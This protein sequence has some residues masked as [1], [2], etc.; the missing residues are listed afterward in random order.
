LAWRET[1]GHQRVERVE[2]DIKQREIGGFVHA[3]DS[4]GTPRRLATWLI[5]SHVAIKP[6][7]VDTNPHDSS[8]DANALYDAVYGKRGEAENRTKDAQ[9][10]LL[11]T[12]ASCHRS[13]ANECQLLLSSLARTPMRAL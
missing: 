2:R 6:R 12:R 4:W 10:G 9:F 8:Y 3:A 7:F 13:L 1:R 5:C 11:G